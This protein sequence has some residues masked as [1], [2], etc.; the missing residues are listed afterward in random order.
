VAVTEIS[1]ALVGAKDPLIVTGYSSRHY[2]TV[3][4]LVDLANVV[5]RLR[6]LDTGRSDMCFL[7]DHWA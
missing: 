1:K 6:V 4:A 2:S 7:A 3:A 5:K